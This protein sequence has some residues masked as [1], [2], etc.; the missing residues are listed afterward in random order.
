MSSRSRAS[1]SS[2]SVISFWLRITWPVAP[3]CARVRLGLDPYPTLSCTNPICT[4]P[5]QAKA[6]SGPKAAL[7]ARCAAARGARPPCVPGQAR[8]ACR[9]TG[10]APQT[11]ASGAGVR[12]DPLRTWC[13]RWLA[14]CARCMLLKL[15]PARPPRAASSPCWRHLGS[16]RAAAGPHLLPAGALRG[17]RLRLAQRGR[18]RAVRRG[19]RG[20]GLSGVRRG[21]RHVL[22]GG[23]RRRRARPVNLGLAGLGAGGGLLARLRGAGPGSAPAWARRSHARGARSRHAGGP[24]RRLLLSCSLP[25]AALS[26]AWRR[27]HARTPEA[28]ERPGG[29]LAHAG[30]LPRLPAGG[31]PPEAPVACQAPC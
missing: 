19:R 4:R 27:V 12:S 6:V 22:G 1:R 24:R 18:R 8:A 25:A 30:A 3:T 2:R 31:C 9:R 5:H 23:R 11:A 17:G 21:G 7:P 29:A 26:R 13:A 16:A 10:G 14:S 20:L 28:L 15:P